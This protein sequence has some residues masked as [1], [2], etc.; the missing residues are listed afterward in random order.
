MNTKGQIVMLDGIDLNGSDLKAVDVYNISEAISE[1]KK[2]ITNPSQC[3]TYVPIWNK[4]YLKKLEN[5]NN[6]ANSA[7]NHKLCVSFI[8]GVPI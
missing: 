2:F 7:E 1:A 6:S 4:I 3:A 5:T 8:Y